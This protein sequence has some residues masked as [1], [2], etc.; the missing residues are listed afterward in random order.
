MEQTFSE[1]LGG[2][3][4][5]RY[6]IFSCSSVEFSSRRVCGF[7]TSSE[8]HRRQVP[9]R[10]GRDEISGIGAGRNKWDGKGK[11]TPVELA[12]A[13]STRNEGSIAGPDDE[14]SDELCFWLIGLRTGDDA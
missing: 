10:A 2:T 14:V 13:T 9:E 8:N 3:F 4:Q 11:I 6:I 7:V 1:S 12:P 5:N